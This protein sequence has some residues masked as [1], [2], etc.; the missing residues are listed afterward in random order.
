M[1]LLTLRRTVM[2]DRMLREGLAG[3][4]EYAKDVPFR[5]LPGLW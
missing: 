4:A 2:E 1:I 5:L 3:Y